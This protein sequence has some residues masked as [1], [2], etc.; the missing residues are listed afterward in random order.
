MTSSVPEAL[1]RALKT[2]KAR[3]D[4]LDQEILVLERMVGDRRG[5][6][7]PPKRGAS[8]SKKTSVTQPKK[9]RQWS[10]EARKRQAE[11]ARKMWAARKAKTTKKKK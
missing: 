7:R 4:E 8:K 6:G 5:P 2:M 11:R 3:R 10:E 9:K 1:Q